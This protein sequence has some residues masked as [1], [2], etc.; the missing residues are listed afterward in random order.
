MRTFRLFFF[1]ILTSIAVYA[2]KTVDTQA[3]GIDQDKKLIVINHNVADFN[4]TFTGSKTYISVNGQYLFYFQN[5]IKELHTGIRYAV[6]YQDTNYQLYFTNLPIIKMNVDEE[7]RDTPKVIGNFELYAPGFNSISSAVGI[8]YRG[9][10]SQTYPKKSMEIEF[11]TST[12]GDQEQELSLLGL[13]ES[14]TW[15]LQAMY[16][17]ALRT[18][19]KTANDLWQQI[20]PFVY[21]AD[22]E[23]KAQSGIRMKYAELFLNNQYRGIYA[24]GEK[25][26]RKSLQLKKL[27]NNTIKGEL[28]KANDW[29]GA[30]MFSMLETYNNDSE[31]WS[32]YEK[33]YPKEKTDWSMMHSLVDFVIN[34]N[35][36][37]FREN[38]P[39]NFDTANLVDYFIFLNLLRA[40]DNSGKN[41]YLAK[42]DQGEKYFYVPWDLDGVFGTIWNGTNENIVDDLLFN[43]LYIRLWNEP[44]FRKNLAERWNVLRQ[45]IIT[46]ENIDELFDSN[47]ATLLNNLAY[48]RENIAWPAFSADNSQW[49]YQKSW[50]ER[51]INFLDGSFKE[52]STSDP[53]SKI[54]HATLFPNPANDYFRIELNMKTYMNVSV[55]DVNGRLVLRKQHCKT[56]DNINTSSLSTGTYFVHATTENSQ[57]T[58]KLIITR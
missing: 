58:G 11:Y 25:V 22:K 56:D 50:I 29:G 20:H 40:T 36:S 3:F 10:T 6:T 27:K 31:E 48:E 17:E 8:E 39:I 33:K 47:R 38:Y 32:G 57:I 28:Y 49:E 12:T 18:N 53:K 35:D 55:Y 46:K 13:S 5:S 1:F 15:N 16:N 30:T 26:N 51:R 52:L 21:Y 24:V 54:L 4:N 43:H 2:Q 19:S 23:P 37:N 14:S 45:N 41:F 34:A 42:Y 7:I 44:T 9:A